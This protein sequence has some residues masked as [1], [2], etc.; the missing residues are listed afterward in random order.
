MLAGGGGRSG[1]GREQHGI[2]TFLKFCHTVMLQS[3]DWRS[4]LPSWK[5]RDET[6]LCI[7]KILVINWIIQGVPFSALCWKLL[8]FHMYRLQSPI[9]Y[10]IPYT[11]S[12]VKMS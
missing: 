4:D 2:S 12:W 11:Q 9:T 3:A 10:L 6:R 8:L 7:F 5:P 1:Q